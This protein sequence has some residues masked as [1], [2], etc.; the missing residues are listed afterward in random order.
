MKLFLPKKL[1][2]IVSLLLLTSACSMKDRTSAYGVSIKLPV[3]TQ[4]ALG[5]A[6]VLPSSNS[7]SNALFS[8]AALV[9]INCFA[10]N[11]VGSGIPVD[12]RFGCTKPEQGMGQMTGLSPVAGGTIDA[13]VP[14]GASR[15]LQLIGFSSTLA[16][17][18]P[19][20][21]S[22]PPQKA[23]LDALGD[24]Y[25]LGQ[26]T[27]DVFSDQTVNIQAVFDP[28]KKAFNNCGG[29]GGG[30][31]LTFQT[32]NDSKFAK[33]S[34]C[35]R[36]EIEAHNFTPGPPMPAVIPTLV[37][38]AG[39]SPSVFLYTDSTCSTPYI[40]GTPLSFGSNPFIEFYAR[41]SLGTTDFTMQ[42]STTATGWNLPQITYHVVNDSL[43]MT[44]PTPVPEMANGITGVPCQPL[45]FF[46]NFLATNLDAG[47]HYDFLVYN[48]SGSTAPSAQFYYS[49]ADCQNQVVA[50]AITLVSTHNRQNI[51]DIVFPGVSTLFYRDPVAEQLS[52]SI[53]TKVGA[54]VSA[55]PAISSLSFSS[56]TVSTSTLA[57]VALDGGTASSTLQTINFSNGSGANV[58]SISVGG[59]PAT[60]TAAPNTITF[61]APPK[62]AS[63]SYNVTLTGTDGSSLTLG[64]VT[65]VNFDSGDGS[66]ASPYAIS[67][68]SQLANISGYSSLNFILNQNLNASS[69]G[70][71]L[72]GGQNYVS[73]DLHGNLD[74]ASH[75]ISNL[76]RPLFDACYNTSSIHHLNFTAPTITSGAGS[77]STGT[78][79]DSSFGSISY[80]SITGGTVTNTIAGGY[81][82]GIAGTQNG[83]T[84]SYSNSTATINS[85]TAAASA[86]GLVGQAGVNAVP[87]SSI[88]YSWSAANVVSDF[89]GGTSYVGGLIGTGTALTLDH[90]FATGNVTGANSANTGGLAGVVYDASSA[91][92]YSFASGSVSGGNY[93]GGF[94]G[95]LNQ[96]SISKSYSIGSVTGNYAG[97]FVGKNAAS[98]S[99]SYARPASVTGTTDRGRFAVLTAGSTL[100]NCY[101][102]APVGP[103]YASPAPDA[104]NVTGPDTFANYVGFS[105]ADWHGASAPSGVV[106]NTPSLLW[107]CTYPSAGVSCAF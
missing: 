52:P 77:S 91:L 45:T 10:L 99:Y 48:N 69:I 6:L 72:P 79:C 103:V 83:G 46:K 32:I 30:M 28:T 54:T 80:V 37:S 58:A 34:T 81:V 23:I 89:T 97:G 61:L 107:L 55:Q 11:V 105:G 75:T 98:I 87:A 78:V 86:G 3:S 65:Y 49:Q 93:V 68:L 82:G 18:C 33:N 90:T 101:S 25:L 44:T 57:N 39:G 51:Y 38:M 16:V 106:A 102:Y 104:T 60:F 67:N 85:H 8:P 71:Y 42:I 56:M 17:G 43:G 47:V 100:T 5:N 94:I 21:D 73:I 4:K 64:N 26:T 14:A 36:I 74:G 19:V 27:V 70:T 31:E 1:I 22:S 96:G 40:A 7:F 63:G 59:S 53:T 35:D 84:I 9:G 12:T 50:S 24:P 92:S 20:F 76:D 41:P 2:P 29:G 15:T 66:I 95:L 13:M 88:H 62:P